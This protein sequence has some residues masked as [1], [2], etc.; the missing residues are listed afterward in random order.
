MFSSVFGLLD[1]SSSVGPFVLLPLI[2][3][4]KRVRLVMFGSFVAGG[5]A[6]AV[7]IG[8]DL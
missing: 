2:G 4:I 6:V 3:L 8:V 1:S 5:L 7:R